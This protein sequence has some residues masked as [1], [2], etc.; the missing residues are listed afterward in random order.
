MK[1]RIPR[2]RCLKMNT[3]VGRLEAFPESSSGRYSLIAL[4]TTRARRYSATPLL[5][6][7]RSLCSNHLMT[8]SGLEKIHIINK[9][10]YANKLWH[11][12]FQ[13]KN[14]C[15]F[16]V[17]LTKFSLMSHLSSFFFL[18]C[19]ALHELHSPITLKSMYLTTIHNFSSILH[20]HLTSKTIK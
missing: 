4:V 11:K 7:A 17:Y 13:V 9:S 19:K 14:L 18:F 2:T 5:S 20:H 3:R 1:S 6:T 8:D 12:N 10:I 16:I 15:S